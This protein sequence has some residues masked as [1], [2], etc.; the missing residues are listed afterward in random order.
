MILSW[1][2]LRTRLQSDAIIGSRVSTSSGLQGSRS[3]LR[4][5]DGPTAPASTTNVIQ[6]CC[7]QLTSVNRECLMNSN[8]FVGRDLLID[9]YISLSREREKHPMPVRRSISMNS[10]YR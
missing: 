1:L 7:L 5:S 9:V 2:P 4:L 3:P 10:E 6:L 8:Q